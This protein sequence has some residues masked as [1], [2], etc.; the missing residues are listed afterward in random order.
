MLPPSIAANP[1]GIIKRE[2]GIRVCFPMRLNAGRKSAA[3][4]MFCRTEERHPT[5]IEVVATTRCSLVPAYL[6]IA[7]AIRD[8]T[9]VRS[10]PNPSIITAAIAMTAFDANPENA[11]IGDMRP[12]QA[13]ERL[14]RMATRS[15]RTRS[16]T[17][18]MTVTAR[19]PPRRRM[20][21][22]MA[23]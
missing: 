14:A 11:S 16:L 20:L 18:R 2:T 9:P 4:P 22:S 5:V 8:V 13:S 12:S 15:I 1:I 17:K 6:M 10:I 21:V 7:L 23:L 3:D 19:T